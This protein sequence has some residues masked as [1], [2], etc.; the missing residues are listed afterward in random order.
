MASDEP[1]R[2]AVDAQASSIDDS[3]ES[4][5]VW[6]G[7]GPRPWWMDDPELK[8]MRRQV[9]DDLEN[10]PDRGPYT[11]SDPILDDI[12]TGAGARELREAREGLT[13]AQTRY[14]EAIR[15]A[16]TRGLSWGE[17][18]TVLG[19]PRQLLHRRFGRRLGSRRGSNER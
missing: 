9:F 16:R 5:G 11:E 19:V 18:G 4:G 14:A 10:A 7:R 17:I 6:E 8:A 13:A 3:A 15:W 2:V 12:F 1:D